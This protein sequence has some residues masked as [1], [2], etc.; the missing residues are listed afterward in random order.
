MNESSAVQVAG[1]SV[2][3]VDGVV[4]YFLMTESGVM[5]VMRSEMRVRVRSLEEFAVVDWTPRTAK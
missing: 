3:S 1:L 4:E 2:R 5:S